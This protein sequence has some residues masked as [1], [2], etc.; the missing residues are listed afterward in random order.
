LI[1]KH[2]VRA[3]ILTPVTK[4]VIKEEKIKVLKNKN[5]Y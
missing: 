1:K 2:V 5:Y 4:E 3:E